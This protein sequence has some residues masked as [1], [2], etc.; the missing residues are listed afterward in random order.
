MEYRTLARTG[1][2]V[3]TIGMGCWAIGGDAWGPVED[4]DSEDA[5]RRAVELG[6]NFFDTADVYGRGHSE[7]LVGR[8][9]KERRDDVVIA[10]K[11]GL[12]DSHR[13]VV[14]NIYSDPQLLIERADESLRRL[15][16]DRIDVYQCHL[17]WDENTET[18]LEAFEALKAQGK[19][20]FYGVSTNDVDHL[21]HFNQHGTCDV[22]Q[23]DYSIL[24]RTP[25]E[26][27]LP[28]AQEENIGTIVRGPLRMG[29]LTG[30]FTPDSTFPEGDVRNAWPDEPW[31]RES[32]EKVERLRS[33]ANGTSLGEIALRFVLNH[34]AVHVA[35][36]GAKNPAQIE[37]NVR[38]GEGRL[39]PEAVRLI[40]EIAPVA[41]A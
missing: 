20:R 39:G 22:V 6:V 9:L 23:F 34:P 10:T 17:W 11:V 33:L 38:A 40:E 26:E 3:A 16:T 12:W 37:A 41:A 29:L 36:P 24:N 31:W 2:R 19:I 8:A 21:R 4:R 25:E 18:F 13:D 5:I 35:I 15:Q 28:Y 30:K 14:P 7:E 27:L 1:L 32:L